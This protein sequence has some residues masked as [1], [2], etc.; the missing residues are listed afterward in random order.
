M[1]SD[2]YRDKLFMNRFNLLDQ[3]HVNDFVEWNNKYHIQRAVER[4]RGM[5][6]LGRTN[7]KEDQETTN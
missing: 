3:R 2:R 4:K 5:A 7:E 6:Q 1:L